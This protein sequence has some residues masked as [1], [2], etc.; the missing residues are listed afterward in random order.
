MVWL[1]RKHPWFEAAVPLRGCIVVVSLF[2]N[3]THTINHVDKY[4]AL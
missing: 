1:V 4:Y 2:A 3:A